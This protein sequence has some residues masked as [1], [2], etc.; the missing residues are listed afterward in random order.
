VRPQ[1]TAP[2][3]LPGN[4]GKDSANGW[5]HPVAS[6]RGQDRVR[7]ALSLRPSLPSTRMTG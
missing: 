5:S 6:G 2:E 4:T 1:G 7:P 3:F